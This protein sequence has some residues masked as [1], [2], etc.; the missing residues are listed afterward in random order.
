MATADNGELMALSGFINPYPGRLGVVE[1]G[2]LADLL[3]VDGNP[4]DDINLV[5]NPEKN[6]AVIMKDGRIYK[7][8]LSKWGRNKKRVGGAVEFTSR[9]PVQVFRVAD[10]N[11]LVSVPR[12][13]RR[14]G[15]P[16]H[17][18][19]ES[20]VSGSASGV[21]G[22]LCGVRG[23]GSL[24][25]TPTAHVRDRDRA[26][27]RCGRLVDHHPS[28]ARSSRAAGSRGDATGIH[29]RRPRAPHRCSQLRLSN[30]G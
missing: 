28:L 12:C 4:L 2:A 21:G 23:L 10:C 22:R 3:L 5:A 20:A 15:H 24:A 1:V 6:F 8:T 11:D 9:V 19:F 16:C 14:V 30:P 17:L 25:F 29:R 26:V 13:A 18:L 7:N 27:S